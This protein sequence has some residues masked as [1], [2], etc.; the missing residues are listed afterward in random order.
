MKKVL[1]ILVA[2]MM[3]VC[4]FGAV[5]ETLDPNPGNT[6]IEEPANPTDPTDPADPD[7]GEP[8]DG[9]GEPDDG[10]GEPTEGEDKPAEEEKPASDKKHHSTK[11]DMPKTGDASIAYG[12][13][14]GVAALATAGYGAT[15]KARRK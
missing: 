11:K 4:A 6:N 1:A 2:L 15:R 5:A 8:D 10:E 14:V 3:L 13:Y 7:E 12:L 9:E